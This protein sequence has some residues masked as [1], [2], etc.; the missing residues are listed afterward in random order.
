MG[1]DAACGGVINVLLFP[2]DP[3]PGAWGRGVGLQRGR[4][5]PEIRLEY[6]SIDC[7]SEESM[8]SSSSLSTEC[9]FS[10]LSL[11]VFLVCDLCSSISL[12]F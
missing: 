11:L 4:E 12:D 7:S 6:W 8:S 2:S 3:S 10:L 9:C 1:D 5:P